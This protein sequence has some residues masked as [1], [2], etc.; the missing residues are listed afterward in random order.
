MNY[1]R[2]DDLKSLEVGSGCCIQD[3]AF[4]YGITQLISPKII[5]EI[6]TNFGVSA[7]AMA[8]AMKESDAPTGHI[9]TFDVVS[10]EKIVLEQFQKMNV[11]DII[12]Y[13]PFKTSNNVKDLNLKHIDMCFIDGDHTYEGVERDYENLK[14]L[15]DYMVFHDIHCNSESRRQFH[16]IPKNTV[17]I[18]DRPGGHVW[19]KGKLDRQV[20]EATFGGFGIV[21]G[22]YKNDR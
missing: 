4:L 15:C 22:E 20:S 7:I 11:Q 8:L 3:Y 18:T 2:W 9:Y 13:L 6:G 14:H 10:Y 12:T 21:K 5:V 17:T 19:D 16:D 1:E